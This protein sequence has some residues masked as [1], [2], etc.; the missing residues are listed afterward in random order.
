MTITEQYRQQHA[1]LLELAG[2]ISSRLG[3]EPLDGGEVRMEL[4]RLAGLLKLHL[5]M[6]DEVL[7][8][9]LAASPD[10]EVSETARIFA[11]E[12]GG[13]A[14]AFG[15]YNE[16][17]AV[18]TIEREPAMFA[19]ETRRVFAALARRIDREN[20]ELYPLLEG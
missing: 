3:A 15:A 17:W 9:S 6:E 19:E 5:A 1:R 18:D 14:A 4:S 16:R 10:P 8:P 11:E 20:N 7:Y 2:A 12:M 13:L